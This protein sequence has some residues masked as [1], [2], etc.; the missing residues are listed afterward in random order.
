MV[1]AAGAKHPIKFNK[2]KKENEKV[3]CMYTEKRAVRVSEF[4]RDI[5]CFFVAAT[6]AFSSWILELKTQTEHCRM[7]TEKRRCQ[8]KCSLNPAKRMYFMFFIGLHRCMYLFSS[9]SL[10]FLSLAG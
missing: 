4:V 7:E 1:Q 6:A 5:L 8:S 3:Q 9:S 10:L 2:A